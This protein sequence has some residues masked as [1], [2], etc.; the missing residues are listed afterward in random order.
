MQQ[1]TDLPAAFGAYRQIGGV[2]EFASFDGS[3]G[4]E[5][6]CLAAIRAAIPAEFGF[7]AGALRELGSRAI[8]L[9]EF[10]GDWC[11]PAS[12]R[13]IRVGKWYGPND[14]EY[15]S[16]E[17]VSLEGIPGEGG[18]YFPP[19]P[20]SGGQFAYAFQCPPGSLKASPLDVQGLFDAVYGFLLP[21]G[22]EA[23]IRDWSSPQL[24]AV[25]DWFAS[26]VDGWGVFLFTIYLKGSGR[27]R[28]VAASSD[29]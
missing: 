19:D 11:N 15:D 13:L 22:E 26:G 7:D 20:G 10:L 1:V 25:S 27:L 2:L 5:A 8:G 4:S 12:G 17:L 21:A 24:D 14:T 23:E 18:V 3:D 29:Y 28:V 16:P 6:D 9:P